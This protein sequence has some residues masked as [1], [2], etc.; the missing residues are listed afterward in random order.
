M[1][2]SGSTPSA[3]AMRADT[4][5]G[6]KRYPESTAK[7]PKYRKDQNESAKR[8]KRV[9]AIQQCRQELTKAHEKNKLAG[10]I[11]HE[12]IYWRGWELGVSIAASVRK[13]IE[14]IRCTGDFNALRNAFT[15]HGYTVTKEEDSTKISW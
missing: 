10:Q 7:L 13:P 2:N 12:P 11:V 3:N 9:E 6:L 5:K 4:D 15:A 8:H 1:G 14:S